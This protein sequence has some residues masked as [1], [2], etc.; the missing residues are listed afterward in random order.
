MVETL[1]SVLVFAVMILVLCV[2]PFIALHMLLRRYPF[3]RPEHRTA[4]H[5]AIAFA[6]GALLFN[7]IVSTFFAP[8]AS[9]APL[10]DILSGLHL[11]SL[12]LSW[13]CLWGAVALSVLVRRRRRRYA[14]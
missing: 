5:C 12:A 9:S 7:L 6:G 8:E 14:V 4:Y 11:T 13:L 3:S 2:P 10:S 1:V